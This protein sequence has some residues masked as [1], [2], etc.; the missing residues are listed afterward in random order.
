MFLYRLNDRIPCFKFIP[1]PEAGCEGSAKIQHVSVA[2]DV[3][4]G[5]PIV[6]TAIVIMTLYYGISGEITQPL[7]M[8]A[9]SFYVTNIIK[10]MS[11]GMHKG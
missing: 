2:F 6:V 11:V 7:F 1:F 3:C 8:I 4:I 5:P 9:F 10:L